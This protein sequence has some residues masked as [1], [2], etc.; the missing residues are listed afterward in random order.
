MKNGVVLLTKVK[1]KWCFI[2]IECLQFI[3]CFPHAPSHLIVGH[4]PVAGTGAIHHCFAYVETK[5][6][7]P[8]PGKCPSLHQTSR[9]ARK[10]SRLSSFV[11]LCL[12]PARL[13]KMVCFDLC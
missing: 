12:H 10:G 4:S 5:D 6:E 8:T 11:L 7:L 13:K 9:P 3:G 1:E 2:F